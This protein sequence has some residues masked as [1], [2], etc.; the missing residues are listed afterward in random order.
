MRPIEFLRA[1]EEGG[2]EAYEAHLS[3]AHGDLARAAHRLATWR[4]LVQPHGA[5]PP[6]PVEVWV[7]AREIVERLDLTEWQPVPSREALAD[8]CR[9]AGLDVLPS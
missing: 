7:A 1:L 9:R 5:I 8:Y 6:T 2:R 3:Q 4:L